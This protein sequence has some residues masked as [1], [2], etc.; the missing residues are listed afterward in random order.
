[1][2]N[3]LSTLEGKIARVV[4]LCQALRVENSQLRQQ[5]VVAES[6]H[7]EMAER[8]EAARARIEQLAHQIP[9]SKPSAKA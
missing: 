1:M 7:R 5:L 2:L 4:A 6:E 8:M 3:E 9:E